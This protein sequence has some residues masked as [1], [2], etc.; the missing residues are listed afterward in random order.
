MNNSASS[1]NGISR[2]GFVAMAAGIA[3]ACALAP[4]VGNGS[5]VAKADESQT[6]K[7]IVSSTTKPYCFVDEDNNVCGYDV[8]VLKLCEEKLDG[9]YTFEFEAMEFSAMIASLQSGACDLVSCALAR[10]SERMEKFIFPDEPYCVGPMAAAVRADSGITDVHTLAGKSLLVSP[11]NAYY[12]ALAKYN[13]EHP[14]E[15]IDLVENE[16]GNDTVSWFRAVANG[17]ADAAYCLESKFETVQEG[18]GTDLVLTDT[19]TNGLDFFML[20]QGME[21]L[22]D[23]LTTVLREAKEDGTLLELEEEWLGG[24]VFGENAEFIESGVDIIVGEGDT[25][26]SVSEDGTVLEVETSS[27]ADGTT[28]SAASSVADKADSSDKDAK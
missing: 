26:Y 8:D 1:T 7:I 9:K 15:A 10:T 19:I 22:A 20:R 5:S 14:D 6:V 3:G 21:E 12:Q 25:I 28:S 24:D 27:S 23:D 13:E 18:A 11:T 4:V 16:N 2:R 17:Q